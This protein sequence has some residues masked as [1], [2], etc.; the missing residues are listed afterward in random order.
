MLAKFS[1]LLQKLTGQLLTG[2]SDK[3]SRPSVIDLDEDSAPAT[4]KP[5]RAKAEKQETRR[6]ATIKKE[7][8]DAPAISHRFDLSKTS[9]DG[10]CYFHDRNGHSGWE[11]KCPHSTERCPCRFGL[12]RKCFDLDKKKYMILEESTNRLRKKSGLAEM[13]LAEM[14]TSVKDHK[15]CS[16][17]EYNNPP[18]GA[19]HGL[20]NKAGKR[21]DR[22]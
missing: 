18:K 14:L 4:A 20:P 7:E 2:A 10:H 13:T 5:A 9:A 17:A 15:G 11:S 8:T 3:A 12:I 21:R 19:A 6:D 22:K 16:D 1:V